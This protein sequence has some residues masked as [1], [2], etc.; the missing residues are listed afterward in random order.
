MKRCATCGTESADTALFCATCGRTLDA[1]ES[2]RE[3]ATSG[4]PHGSVARLIAASAIAVSLVAVATVAIVHRNHTTFAIPSIEQ[5]AL[6]DYLHGHAPQGTDDQTSL[7]ECPIV[8]FSTIEADVSSVD[9]HWVPVSSQPDNANV[10]LDRETD[11]G[12]LAESCNFAFN[13]A[14]A[15]EQRLDLGLT[16][17][18]D[19]GLTD[20]AYAAKWAAAHHGTT[21]P[22]TPART[23][24]GT[25]LDGYCFS[26]TET[27]NSCSFPWTASDVYLEVTV[28]AGQQ[29]LG[30]ALLI[31]LVPQFLTGLHDLP[32]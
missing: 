29:D 4:R 3:T 10:N 31:K 22:A 9:R 19:P 18:T 17:Y 25:T 30:R 8:S 26:G 2:P 16:A 13:D 27:A 11:V 32:K 24:I 21:Y 28:P 5:T 12:L 20:K 7:S 15:P 6:R 14:G 1:S 23:D